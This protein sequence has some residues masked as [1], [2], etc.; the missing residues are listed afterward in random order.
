MLCSELSE[1]YFAD[2]GTK[3]C[4]AFVGR[5]YRG[6]RNIE[7]YMYAAATVHFTN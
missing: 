3:M 7:L 6:I 4:S 2:Q 5:Y 1:K